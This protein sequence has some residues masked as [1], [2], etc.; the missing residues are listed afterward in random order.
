[1]C[2][3]CSVDALL[4]RP[5]CIEMKYENGVRKTD[6]DEG[7]AVVLEN[8]YISRSTNQQPSCSESIAKSTTT[9]WID[10]VCVCRSRCGGVKIY[11][12]LLVAGHLVD[13]PLKRD[14]IKCTMNHSKNYHDF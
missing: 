8:R 2:V 12:Y 9:W 14:E 4:S 13:R 3:V 7:G 11:Y 5:E 10:F 6:V 1:M